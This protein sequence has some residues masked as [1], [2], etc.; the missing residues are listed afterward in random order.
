MN[1]SF[2]GAGLLGLAMATTGLV[3]M[4]HAQQFRTMPNVMGAPQYGTS[5]TDPSGGVWR[6]THNVMGAPQYGTSTMGPNGQH[7]RTTQNVMGQP[8][9]GSTTTCN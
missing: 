4:A 3:S 6:T 9:Y 5:T 7:C 8:Q 2:L 1:K